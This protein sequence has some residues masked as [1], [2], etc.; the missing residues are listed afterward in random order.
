V[1]TGVAGAFLLLASVLNER[2]AAVSLSVLPFALAVLC[3]IAK[4]GTA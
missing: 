3:G 2:D 1:V 4:S